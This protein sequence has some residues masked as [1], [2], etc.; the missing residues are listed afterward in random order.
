M[1]IL[2]FTLPLVLF[3]ALA[4]W[5]AAGLFGDR[6][7]S[8]LPNMLVDRPAP[9]TDL[10]GLPGRGPGLDDDALAGGLS[11]VNIW[12]S[13]CAPCLAEHPILTRLAEDEGVTI[14]GINRDDEPAAALAWLERHGDPFARVGHD[15][16]GRA[17][18]DW[19]TTGVP[20]TFLIDRQGHIRFHFAG[21]L[22]PTVV[23]QELLPL[24]AELR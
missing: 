17:A 12:A 20:E 7:P 15:P 16:D 5:L 13:W 8:R 1:R 2:L 3:A 10:P 14:H 23:A 18:I 11:L 19:G 21:P 6:D 22:P 4:S 9:A 24:I